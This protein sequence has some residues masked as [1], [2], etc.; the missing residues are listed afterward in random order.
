[1]VTEPVT[2]DLSKMALAAEELIKAASSHVEAATLSIGEETL[3]CLKELTI[4]SSLIEKSMD[5]LKTSMD[6]KMNTLNQSILNLKEDVSELKK[7][8]ALQTKNQKLEWAFSNA[9]YNS[10]KYYKKGGYGEVDSKIFVQD[11]MLG[12]KQG[13]GY[14]ITNKSM[15]SAGA[16]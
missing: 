7:E 9:G 2:K 8:L 4:G 5:S 3:D 14:D 1:M 13:R 15:T 12:F 10:F 6:S 11:I 16:G